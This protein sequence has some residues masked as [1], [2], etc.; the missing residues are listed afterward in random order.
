MENTES[1]EMKKGDWFVMVR[2]VDLAVTLFTLGVKFYDPHRPYSYQMFAGKRH[3][4]FMFLMESSIKGVEPT[5]SLMK[6]WPHAEDEV[7]PLSLVSICKRTI[8]ERRWLLRSLNGHEFSSLQELA[9][10]FAVVP[11]VKVAA[12]AYALGFEK[13]KQPIAVSQGNRVM[14]VGT[15]VPEWLKPSCPSFDHLVT[16]VEQGLAYIEQDGNDIDPIAVAGAAF[17][18]V[19]SWLEHL[20]S[21]KPYLQFNTATGKSY[22]VKE[23][24]D[25]WKELL[26]L[27]YSPA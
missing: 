17:L 20:R 24:S 26:E 8:W 10:G 6:A 23:G 11:S 7:G 21:D 19:I 13:P 5:T 16:C 22:W 18:N 12:I 14:V 3:I 4:R 25:K 2:L 9:N 27:G 1:R 15:E